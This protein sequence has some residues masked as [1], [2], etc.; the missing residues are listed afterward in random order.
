MAMNES[1]YKRTS[2]VTKSSLKKKSV[3]LIK[4]S[5]SACRRY[6][7]EKVQKMEKMMDQEHG[8]ALMLSP[9][10]FISQPVSP[11]I[12][13]STNPFQTNIQFGHEAANNT[14]DTHDLNRLLNDGNVNV[15]G[16]LNKN[17]GGQYYENK[18]DNDVIK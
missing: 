12:S 11:I 8:A 10:N 3:S 2:F 9:Q 5:K 4:T 15:S 17:D 1:P 6:K 7:N 14:I 16:F 18:N 13:H